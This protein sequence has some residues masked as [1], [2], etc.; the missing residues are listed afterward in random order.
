M[1]AGVDL[2]RRE[3][4]E[5]SRRLEAFAHDRARYLPL[6]EQVEAV[7]DELR[8]RVGQSFTLAELA[9]AYGGAEDWSRDVVAERAA[10]PGWPSTL[11][12]VESAAF[13]RYQRGAVDYAP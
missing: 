9:D 5:G 7:I 4:K 8:R 2:A 13:D 10:S 11:A 1:S 3:W 6:L 12:L